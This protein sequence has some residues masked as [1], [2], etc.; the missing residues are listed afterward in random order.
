MKAIRIHQYGGPE[1]L[2][3]EELP[4]PTPGNGQVRVRVEAI[5]VNFIDTKHR[6][7]EFK[8]ILPPLPLTLGLEGAGVVDEVGPGVTGVKP[9]DRLGWP[10]FL[11]SYAT[12]LVIPI[13]RAIIL[14]PKVSCRQAAAVLNNGATAHYLTH[15]TYPVK[16][17]DLCLVHAAA[18]GVGR[19]L[20]R[21]AKLRGARVFGTVSTE[22]KALLAREAGAD[23]TI[24]YTQQDFEREVRRLTHG[25]GVNVVYDSIGK[26]TFEKS[27]NCLAVR[28]TLVLFSQASGPV[29]AFN[30]WVL[31]E[32]GSLFLTAPGLPNHIASREDFLK[33]V[34]PVL[35]W[36]AE[37]ELDV[38]VR[39]YPMEQVTEA[40]HAVATRQALAKLLLTP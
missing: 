38:A 20:C 15:T 16:A 18:G 32:K 5:G 12:D 30:P 37:G 23:E 26:D 3:V 19:L 22:A 14:P 11:G 1:V 35:R 28:G 21:M 4:T 29:P 36:A 24:L 40:H 34:E 17:G 33:H 27:L 6:L 8:H 7:G 13:D 10:S 2:K 31:W 25:K 39:Q 9:G